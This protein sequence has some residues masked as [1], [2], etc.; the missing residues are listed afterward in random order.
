[1]YI[2]NFNYELNVTSKRLTENIEELS[3]LD[4]STFNTFVVTFRTTEIYSLITSS[5][6]E[7][8]TKLYSLITKDTDTRGINLSMFE[9]NKFMK[10]ITEI[11]TE[12]I[13]LFMI[14]MI[15][16]YP[17][18]IDSYVAEIGADDSDDM[19]EFYNSLTEEE[20]WEINRV[21]VA[22]LTRNFTIKPFALDE[23]SNEYEQLE[24]TILE[25]FH[26]ISSEFY[27]YKFLIPVIEVIK[28]MHIDTSNTYD[29][30]PFRRSITNS[31][32]TSSVENILIVYNK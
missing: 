21:I 14:W 8:F 3:K 2:E 7:V 31:T 4:S 15:V 12:W 29:I 9:T 25:I 28:S 19:E 5:V 17:P 27:D 32:V 16:T 18:D 6:N 26:T 20:I 11:L 10:L 24:I 13:V 22:D 1:M 23:N 30:F